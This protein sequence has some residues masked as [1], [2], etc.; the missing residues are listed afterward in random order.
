MCNN[1]VQWTMLCLSGDLGMCLSERRLGN[2]SR[3]Q[4]Y[5]SP[6]IIG[7]W[8]METKLLLVHRITL[9]TRSP[10]WLTHDNCIVDTLPDA[11]FCM[12]HLLHG[13]WQSIVSDGISLLL[14]SAEFYAKLRFYLCPHLMSFV[15]LINCCPFANY[16]CILV[17]ISDQDPV[18]WSKHILF[19]TAKLVSK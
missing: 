8:C 6:G 5:A 3:R 13:I 17:L 2:S 15:V 9:Y 12:L 7:G 19:T 18:N 10:Y 1:V 4:R 14:V 16:I 11:Y